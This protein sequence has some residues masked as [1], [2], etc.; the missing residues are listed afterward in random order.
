ME[1]LGG[2]NETGD[3]GSD[4]LKSFSFCKWKNQI[5]SIS[6]SARALVIGAENETPLQDQYRNA[7]PSLEVFPRV[8]MDVIG[9]GL[10]TTSIHLKL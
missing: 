9:R 7:V 10:Q 4:I 3:F 8:L 2:G 5:N 1:D 6:P